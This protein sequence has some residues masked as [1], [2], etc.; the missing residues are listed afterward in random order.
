MLTA[1]YSYRHFGVDNQD[2]LPS[3]PG[4]KA[5]AVSEASL[6]GLDHLLSVYQSRDYCYWVA[7]LVLVVG[8][9]WAMQNNSL[10]TASQ[11]LAS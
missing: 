11:V 5:I 8:E 1:G 6:A 3:Y 10:A 9:G 4:R 7:A 2:R